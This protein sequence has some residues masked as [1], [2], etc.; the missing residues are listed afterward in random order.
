MPTMQPSTKDMAPIYWLERCNAETR[1]LIRQSQI[2]DPVTREV[3]RE[4]GHGPGDL[5]LLAA[6]IVRP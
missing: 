4:T 6:S 1:R 5:A 3:L 2:V